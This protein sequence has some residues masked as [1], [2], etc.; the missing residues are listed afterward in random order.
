MRLPGT[1]WLSDAAPSLH[2][3]PVGSARRP[4]PWENKNKT[5]E[6]KPDRMGLIT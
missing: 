6:L 2:F 5:F 4:G 1:Q 3:L